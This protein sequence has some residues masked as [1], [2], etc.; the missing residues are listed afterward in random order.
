MDL[1]E[2][3][4]LRVDVVQGKLG[5]GGLQREVQVCGWLGPLALLP[6]WLEDFFSAPKM[7]PLAFWA[8][9]ILTL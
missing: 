1:V 4:G 7:D 9:Q 3:E 5:Y 6:Q 8:L 2:S